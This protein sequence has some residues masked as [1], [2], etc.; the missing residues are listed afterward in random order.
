MPARTLDLEAAESDG[1]EQD[2]AYSV[3]RSKVYRLQMETIPKGGSKGRKLLSKR[4]HYSLGED[5]LPKER[6]R[7]AFRNLA[8][9]NE[10]Q[11]GSSLDKK[12]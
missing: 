11:G 12:R 2:H 9:K 6:H 8:V 10:G 7:Y 5:E 3:V 4:W 1:T